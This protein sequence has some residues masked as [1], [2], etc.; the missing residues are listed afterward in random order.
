MKWRLSWQAVQDVAILGTGVAFTWPQLILWVWRDRSPSDI[1][2]AWGV[3]L[4][5]FGAIPHVRTVLGIGTH[6]GAGSSSLPSPPPS[7]P[8]LPPSSRRAE[9]SGGDGG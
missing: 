2:L 4:L 3:G 6:G 5:T 7:P 1:L 9:G 8:P